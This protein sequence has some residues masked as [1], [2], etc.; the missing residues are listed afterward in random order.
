[1][2]K[3]PNDGRADRP[4]K[5]Y[6]PRR[7]PWLKNAGARF[8]TPPAPDATPGK[9][10][11]SPD[12]VPLARHPAVLRREGGVETVLEAH[13]QRFTCFTEHL[14]LEAVVPVCL[15]LRLGK[16]PF[17]VPADLA[18]GGQGGDRRDLARRRGRRP[19]RRRPARRRRTAELPGDLGAHPDR[20]GRASAPWPA[21]SSPL[22]QKP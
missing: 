22:S 4:Q 21:P 16:T 10:G 15:G 7:T 14:E 6:I 19:A 5:T 1:M 12:L 3:T 20:A 9:L 18:N 2:D 17:G 8:W 13:L 11:F